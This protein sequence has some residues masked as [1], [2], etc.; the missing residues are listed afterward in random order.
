MYFG[1]VSCRVCVIISYHRAVAKASLLTR[2]FGLI[3]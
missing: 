1:A 3:I 2:L